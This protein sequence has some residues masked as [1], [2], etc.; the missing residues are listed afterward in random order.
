[1]LTK[2]MA[3]M[4]NRGAQNLEISRLTVSGMQLPVVGEDPEDMVL[5]DT[6]TAMVGYGFRQQQANVVNLQCCSGR[7]LA[8][9]NPIVNPATNLEFASA[10]VPGFVSNAA[11]LRNVPIADL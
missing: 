10:N 5:C 2:P 1:M 11:Q 4:V 3:V 9:V 7:F 6:G 8:D